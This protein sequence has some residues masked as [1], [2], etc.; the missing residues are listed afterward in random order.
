MGRSTGAGA[1][2]IWT[3]HLRNVDWLP[4]YRGSGYTGPA[5]K[6]HAGAR[7]IDL[8]E[9]ANAQGHVVVGGQCTVR[10]QVPAHVSFVRI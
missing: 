7:S 3:H 9:A 2:S 6:A 10:C 5:F 4:S 1:V 8:V